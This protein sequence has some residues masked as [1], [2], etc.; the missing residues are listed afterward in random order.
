[1]N[2]IFILIISISLLLS[3][4]N[5]KAD[6][7]IQPE[8]QDQLILAVLWFQSSAEMQALFFQGYNIATESLA[9]KLKN[10][11]NKKPKAVIMDIDETVLDNSPVEALSVLENLPFTDS[12]WL[13][14]VKKESALVLPGARDFIEFADSGGVE[15]FYV[16]NRNAPAEFGPTLENLKK[17][18]LPF[19]DSLHLLLKTDVSSKE[20]RRTLVAEKYDILMLIGDNLGDFDQVFESRG[21]DKGFGAVITNKSRFGTDFIVLPNP[22]Y[23]SWIN[24]AIKNQ[25]GTMREKL[26]KVLRTE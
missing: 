14:W 16:S 6:T 2:K 22:M 18:G 26:L 10:K 23:G 21:E 9:K 5:Q 1:M 8:S 3:C 12:L 7:T 15:I 17:A 25:E 19:A 11:A 24:A 20:P 13:S 4:R